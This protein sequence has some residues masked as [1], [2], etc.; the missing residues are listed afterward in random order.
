M[1]E[2]SRNKD[3]DSF[4]AIFGTPAT[5]NLQQIP[6]LISYLNRPLA[7]GWLRSQT[8]AVAVTWNVYAPQ[9]TSISISTECFCKKM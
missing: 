2:I 6:I 4:R 3:S 1:V 5:L 8:T 7:A 9:L